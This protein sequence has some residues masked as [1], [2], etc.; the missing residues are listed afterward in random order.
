[1]RYLGLVLD[2]KWRFEE[3]FHYLWPRVINTAGALSRLLPNLGETSATGRRLYTRMVRSMVLYRSHVWAETLTLHSRTL[4]RQTQRVMAVR[5]IRGYRTVLY[6]RPRAVGT[7]W[8]N[9]LTWLGYHSASL[10]GSATRTPLPSEERTS[11][12]FPGSPPNP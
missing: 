6:T 4:L 7:A 1:M 8:P 9:A 2:P 10:E 5:V 11:H 3:H 12:V